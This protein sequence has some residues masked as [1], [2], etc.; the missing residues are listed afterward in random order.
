[1]R[2]RLRAP[3]GA[4]TITLPDDATI[5]DLIN[6]IIE[7]TSIKKFDIK[8]GYPPRPLLLDQ[9]EKS[10]PLSQLDVTLDGEQLTIGPREEEPGKAT[11]K[12]ES[13][14]QENVASTNKSSIP[15]TSTS[16]FSFTG[17]SAPLETPEKKEKKKVSLQ[18]KAMAG[19]VP[20]IPLPERGATLGT[21]KSNH[22]VVQ[23]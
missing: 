23:Y 1:M 9:Q 11:N 16:G 19:D 14:K 22:G 3:G 20:E 10:L 2:V 8:Y 17:A 15:S 7:K 21:S 5:E 4:S 13:S 18:R 6:Q 12:A